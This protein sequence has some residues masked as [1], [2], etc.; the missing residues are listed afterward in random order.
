ML[1]RCQQVLDF[2]EKNAAFGKNIENR[3][4]NSITVRIRITTNNRAMSIGDFSFRRF[5]FADFLRRRRRFVHF[6]QVLLKSLLLNFSMTI[7]KYS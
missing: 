2:L 4:C 3:I 6:S 5:P 7:V 1:N